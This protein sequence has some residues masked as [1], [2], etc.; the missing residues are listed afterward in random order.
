MVGAVSRV[1]GNVSAETLARPAA[2]DSRLYHVRRF[3]YDTVGSA[4]PI[5][6]QGIT[7]LVG[8]SQIVFGSDYPWGTSLRIAQDLEGCG[9]SYQ[10]LRAI[11]RGNVVRFMPK[12]A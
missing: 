9:F 12:Y 3:Y 7:K 5:A 10:E 1:V 11:D 4:N 8:I 2:P 6:M